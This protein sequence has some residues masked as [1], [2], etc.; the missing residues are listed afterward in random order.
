VM[1]LDLFGGALE[2]RMRMGMRMGM[3]VGE[4]HGDGR[5]AWGCK[6]ARHVCRQHG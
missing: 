2:M 3:A 5:L 1:G 6:Q 4:G